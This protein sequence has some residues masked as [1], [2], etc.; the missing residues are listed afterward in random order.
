MVALVRRRV[1]RLEY[2]DRAE[3][4]QKRNTREAEDLIS[5]RAERTREWDAVVGVGAWNAADDIGAGAVV[6]VDSQS[7]VGEYAVLGDRV[8][9][10]VALNVDAGAGPVARDGVV[11]AHLD[12]VR[13]GF[14]QHAGGAVGRY[15]V[16]GD[17]APCAADR[18]E[19]AGTQLD[20][21]EGAEADRVA[22][23]R[24]DRLRRRRRRG[25]DVDANAAATRD[26]AD[27][28]DDVHG[29]FAAAKPVDLNGRVGRAE[30]IAG[31]AVHLRRVRV[32]RAAADVRVNQ[33]R[34]LEALQVVVAVHLGA[35]VVVGPNGAGAGGRLDLDRLVDLAA[36]INV[37][38]HLD[39]AGVVVAARGGAGFALR[40]D[41]V[42][43]FAGDV[44][45]VVDQNGARVVVLAAG[46]TRGVDPVA[47]AGEVAGLAAHLNRTD[48]KVRISGVTG[49][50]LQVGGVVRRARN[51]P[52]ALQLDRAQVLVA[53]HVTGFAIKLCADFATADVDVAVDLNR[54]RVP[55]RGGASAVAGFTIDLDAI[56][57]AAGS[58]D[59][60]VAVHLHGAHV[61]LVFIRIALDVDAVVGEPD[62]VAV[63]VHLDG[64][65]I[66]GVIFR[67][68]VD[69]HT[70]VSAGDIAI[71]VDF[72]RARV[73]AD[74]PNLGLD[75]DA[76]AAGAGSRDVPVAVDLDGACVPGQV[77]N[78]HFDLHAGV[79]LARDVAVDV[80]GDNA[81]VVAVIAH[82]LDDPDTLV[83]TDD[84]TVAVDVRR[85]GAV[86][87]AG[88]VD[89]DVYALIRVAIDRAV[90]RDVDVDLGC[91]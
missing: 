35:A 68:A 81:R 53:A 80:D 84:V 70:A 87:R 46:L 19:V 90:A 36:D 77:A 91:V 18:A 33:H 17:D 40:I 49:A 21:F 83:A 6:Q 3:A 54:A 4:R 89:I 76:F 75:V 57:A 85:H 45:V 38:V 8:E 58:R 56:A 65:G 11:R 14:Q 48:V 88:D 20:T 31:G 25:V 50:A 72:N 59:V 79:R 15:R 62:D 10:G 2:L 23:D 51:V 7:L 29:V 1:V 73:I 28:I 41:P 37:V 32:A 78:H 71:V 47:A 69:F 60:A 16:V 12:A 74:V 44:E 27:V 67:L 9:L 63:A 26:Q 52:V 34:L 13:V 43:T 39:G 82:V 5:L 66:P 42:V 61:F 22:A 55:V 30:N 24:R 64:A 86:A